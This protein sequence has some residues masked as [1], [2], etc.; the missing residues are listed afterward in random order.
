MIKKLSGPKDYPCIESTYEFIVKSNKIRLWINETELKEIDNK[1]LALLKNIPGAKAEIINWCAAN[2]PNI[3]AVQVID[4]EGKGI[5]AYT[6]DFNDD[7]R[8]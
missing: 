1:T 3:N 7:L 8:G 4:K 2:I 6:V 5:V